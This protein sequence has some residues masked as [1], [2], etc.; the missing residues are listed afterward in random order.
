MDKKKLYQSLYDAFSKAYPDKQKK[1]VQDSVNAF[2][3]SCKKS[4]NL[5]DVINKKIQDLR[6]VA[7][8]SK[9]SLDS[10]WLKASEAKGKENELRSNENFNKSEA[11]ECDLETSKIEESNIPST[12]QLNTINKT[13]EITTDSMKPYSKPVQKKLESE[14]LVLTSDLA[15]LERRKNSG[16]I[17]DDMITE[18]EGK[19]K[20]LNECHNMLKKRKR[21]M[22]RSRTTR[23]LKKQKL[24]MAIDEIPELREKLGVR[25]S[26]NRPRL[27]EDQP[28]LLETI[29]NLALHGSAAHE[30]RRDDVIRTVKTLD[31]LVDKLEE[32]G[33]SLSRSAAYLRLLPRRSNSIEG[34]RHVRT[35]PVKLI[36]ASNDLHR[37]HSDSKFAMTTI[38]HIDEIASILGSNEVTYLSQD[39]KAKIPI[40]VTAAK[41]QAPL[42]MHMEYR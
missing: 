23:R 18:Y 41:S 31:D 16:L 40:G 1:S 39:D 7:I 5:S 29:T 25:T 22:E 30:R 28:F 34:K 17:S 26:A 36:R 12:S 37:E 6:K 20:R 32:N 27:E 38:R 3:N 42:L 4:E 14:I 19:K 9:L 13:I 21:E 15:A 2:W 24:D 10:F 11:S 8:K 35:V 33:F